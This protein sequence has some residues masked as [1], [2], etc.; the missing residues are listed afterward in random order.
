[1]AGITDESFSAMT[2][3]ADVKLGYHIYKLSFINF[4]LGKQPNGPRQFIF[5]NLAPES[6]HHIF[7]VDDSALAEQEQEADKEVDKDIDKVVNKEVDK[8]VDK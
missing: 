1:M 4:L 5:V 2:S 3:N 7:A 6:G 8:E